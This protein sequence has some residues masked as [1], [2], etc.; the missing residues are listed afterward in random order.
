MSDDEKKTTEDGASEGTEPKEE[1]KRAPKKTLVGL[2]PATSETA[3]EPKADAAA[4][5]PEAPAEPESNAGDE[6]KAEAAADEPEST[7]E[8]EKAESKDDAKDDAEPKP[9]KKAQKTLVG[10]GAVSQDEIDA[11]KAEKEAAKADD[12]TEAE[13]KSDDGDDS[14]SEAPSPDAKDLGVAADEAPAQPV[15]ED[16][17]DHEPEGVA[18]AALASAVAG[19]DH[20]E[21]EDDDDHGLGGGGHHDDED[22]EDEL[23]EKRPALYLAEYETPDAVAHAAEAIRDAGYEKWDCHTPYPV[24]GLDQAM[25]LRPTGIGWISFVAAM[26]GL[27]TAILMIQYM[28]NWDYPIVVG[29]K[30]PGAFPSM[31]P[32]MFELTVL[33]C[34]F[35]TLFGLLHLTKL[36]RHHHPIFESERFVAATDDKFFLSVEVS[37]PKFDVSRTR[38]LLEKT[39]PSHLELVEEEIE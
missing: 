39:H 16:K 29:G 32:I 27:V 38:T 3:D 17:A 2:A 4:E 5:E 35:G 9:K 21:D 28:N 7:P 12:E 14:D 24:H 18:A 1:K 13:A 23:P 30:P 11:D 22:E 15:A 34:G 10:L 19:D 8:D 26:T 20:A 36:P 33:L 37:D 31:V 25:G 6:S